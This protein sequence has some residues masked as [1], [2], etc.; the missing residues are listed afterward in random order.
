MKIL[1]QKIEQT[2]QMIVDRLRKSYYEKDLVAT[3]ATVNSI[4]YEVDLKKGYFAILG[5]SWIQFTETGRAPLRNNQPSDF[6]QRLEAWR[7]AK[8]VQIP[9]KTL[10]YMINK[11]GTLL[12]QGKDK[13][14]S[15]NQSNV[16]TDVINESLITEI[17]KAITEAVFKDYYTEIKNNLQQA[18]KITV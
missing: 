7:R 17:T 12:W 4:R 1:K 14:F 9:A 16:I 5:A 11:R 2:A 6:L 13:R 8:N 3:G 10:Q 15:G 18:I